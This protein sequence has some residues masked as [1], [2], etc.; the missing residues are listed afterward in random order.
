[1]RAAGGG[2][3]SSSA[4][5]GQ[6]LQ[7]AE[8][9]APVRVVWSHAEAAVST[10]GVSIAGHRRR[11]RT[12]SVVRRVADPLVS[13]RTRAG[14]CWGRAHVAGHTYPCLFSA[15]QTICLGAGAARASFCPAHTTSR[16]QLRA[17]LPAA[18]LSMYHTAWRPGP[19]CM[20]LRPMY[21]FSL[22]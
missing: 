18:L 20:L 1:M 14:G 7:A 2:S 21:C 12:R 3:C 22:V 16:N 8:L 4:S 13:D 6:R 11:S 10:A 19:L 15:S 9:K 17:Q 5:C